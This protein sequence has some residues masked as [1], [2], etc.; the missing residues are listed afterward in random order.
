MAKQ[1]PEKPQKKTHWR[2]GKNERH[3]K[4]A[5]VVSQLAGNPREVQPATGWTAIDRGRPEWSCGVRPGGFPAKNRRLSHRGRGF[6]EADRVSA[7][8][9]TRRATSAGRTPAI[10]RQ[11]REGRSSGRPDHP[12]ARR[13]P[14]GDHP[15]MDGRAAGE[16]VLPGIPGF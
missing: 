15:R 5:E 2:G 12:A 9:R 8:A 7:A 1:K 3:P 14:V 11:P 4:N 10:D 6:C 16:T 13:L